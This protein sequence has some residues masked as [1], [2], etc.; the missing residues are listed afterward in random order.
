MIIIKI[1]AGLIFVLLGA[2]VFYKGI[3]TIRSKSSGGFIE[4][5][6]GIGFVIIGLLIWLGFIS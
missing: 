3:R 1:I 2:S 4:I 6:A 5:F